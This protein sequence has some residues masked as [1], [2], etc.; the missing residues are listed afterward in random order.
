MI[1]S[2]RRALK[3]ALSFLTEMKW[4][5]WQWLLLLILLAGLNSAQFLDGC[6]DFMVY[7]SNKEINPRDT[8]T[9]AFKLSSPP[10]SVGKE[11]CERCVVLADTCSTYAKVEPLDWGWNVTANKSMSEGECTLT[12]TAIY[13]KEQKKKSQYRTA[14]IEF[15]KVPL[16]IIQV[17]DN[18]TVEDADALVFLPVGGTNNYK[19]TGGVSPYHMKN[20]GFPT[21]GGPPRRNEFELRNNIFTINPILREV[22]I[23]IISDAGE[24]KEAVAMTTISK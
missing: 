24:P 7:P 18:G 15:K 20:I 2:P 5:R 11:P 1:Q 14:S 17:L 19:I 9:Y 12:A 23:S 16:K 13:P 21:E 4:P 10:F 8:E 3:R 22:I 6:D